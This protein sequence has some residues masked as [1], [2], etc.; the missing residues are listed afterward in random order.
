MNVVHSIQNDWISNNKNTKRI[1]NG[2]Q[3]FLNANKQND[4]KIPMICFP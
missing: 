3:L 2:M 4:F 1:F